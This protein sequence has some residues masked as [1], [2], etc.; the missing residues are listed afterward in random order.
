MID[1]PPPAEIAW[2]RS[3]GK[4][5]R[6][7]VFLAKGG[8]FAIK[9]FLTMDQ[10]TLPAKELTPYLYDENGMF[11]DAQRELDIAQRLLHPNVVRI[12]SMFFDGTTTYLVMDF[13]EGK[14]IEDMHKKR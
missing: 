7:E 9:R 12:Y 3:L 13:I 6:A 4:G 8:R 5:E 14:P 2:E 10:I 11:L 1:L